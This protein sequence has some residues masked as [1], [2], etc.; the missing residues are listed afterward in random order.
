VNHLKSVVR[1]GD[2]IRDGLDVHRRH[3]TD[4]GS[5]IE[6]QVPELEPHIRPGNGYSPA[7]PPVVTS[8]RARPIQTLAEHHAVQVQ[9]VVIGWRA[10]VVIAALRSVE[11]PASPLHLSVGEQLFD[12]GIVLH[13]SVERLQRFSAASLACHA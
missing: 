9:D 13:Y 4:P 5:E 12:L 3:V 2:D 7:G 6:A 11:N 1:V 10:S 8:R